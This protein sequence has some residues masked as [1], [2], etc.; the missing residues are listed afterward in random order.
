[1][2]ANLQGATVAEVGVGIAGMRERARQL[3]GRLEIISDQS[4]TTLRV[5]QPQPEIVD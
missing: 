4:G 1:M 5:L 3:G 2:P